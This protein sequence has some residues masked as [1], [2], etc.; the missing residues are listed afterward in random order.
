MIMNRS[1]TNL[2]EAFGVLL[3]VALTTFLLV[4]SG[5]LH[6]KNIIQIQCMANGG[7]VYLYK[8]SEYAMNATFITELL[9]KQGSSNSYRF[10][11][12]DLSYA[13]IA[14]GDLNIDKYLLILP[15]SGTAKC[16]FGSYLEPFRGGWRT[17]F[18]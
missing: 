14:T 4:D 16:V 7:K 13:F 3:D 1:V 10:A 12:A 11:S 2:E 8:G 17:K 15:G 6:A 18:Q 9:P 5:I